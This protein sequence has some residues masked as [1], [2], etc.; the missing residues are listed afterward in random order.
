MLLLAEELLAHGDQVD[1]L[2]FDQSVARQ[3]VSHINKAINIRL[4]KKE[5]Y[6]LAM[7]RILVLH[8]AEIK[9]L[10]RP[11]ILTFKPCKA[12]FYIKSLQ[13]YL[14]NFRPA[15][16]Y[17]AKPHCN[18]VAAMASRAADYQPKLIM[19]ERTAISLDRNSRLNKSRWRYIVPAMRKFYPMADVILSVSKCVGEDLANLIAPIKINQKTIY[20]PIPITTIREKM[21]ADDGHVLSAH[22][23][24]KI[25]IA[26]GRLVAQK[27]YPLLLRAFAIVRMDR[28][29][30]LVILGTGALQK[31]IHNLAQHLAIQSDLIMPGHIINPYPIMRQS[32]VFVM[33]SLWEGMPNALLEA[34]ACGCKVIALD[35]PCGPSE[36]LANGKYGKLLA[37]NTDAHQLA[38]V[39]LTE[40]ERSHDESAQLQHLKKFSV[41]NSSQQ[42]IELQDQLLSTT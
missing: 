28:E 14:N 36:I 9:V 6:Y 30:K 3:S 39:I 10:L 41:A 8:F 37:L 17:S 32:D 20:N 7:L 19:M 25:V 4:L 2:T 12:Q 40:L 23:D 29:C 15:I 35:C 33:T 24:Y 16:L 26:C 42:H 31:H 18:I 11:F 13:S 38:E 5:P 27:N 21:R 22:Q 1:I 34:L